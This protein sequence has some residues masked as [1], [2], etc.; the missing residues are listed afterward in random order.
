MTEDKKSN[1]LSM[2]L[3]SELRSLGAVATN[4]VS[5]LNEGSD[6][7]TIETIIL[8]DASL[9]AQII[10]VANSSK[11]EADIQRNSLYD[12]IVRIGHDGLRS[13]CITIGIIEHIPLRNH[14]QRIM[15][16][17]CLHRS[18]ETAIHAENLT[19]KMTNS[20]S[21]D[22]YIAGLLC[23]VGELAFLSSS[24][25]NLKEYNELTESGLT[26]EMAC[27]SLCDFDFDELSEQIVEKWEL[28]ILIN[29]AFINNPATVT[30]N[31]IKVAF[32]LTRAYYSGQN[33]KAFI[34]VSRSLV[35]DF[36]FSLKET[37]HFI[38]KGIESSQIEFNRYGS[39][40]QEK[41]NPFQ[42]GGIKRH[43][44]EYG[45][46]SNGK[47]FAR[48]LDI[49]GQNTAIKKFVVLAQKKAS[50]RVFY[51]I[52]VDSLHGYTSFDRVVIAEVK[53]KSELKAVNVSG[54][55]AQ[56]LF[57]GFSF[58][59]EVGGSTVSEIIDTKKPLYISQK[60]NPEIYECVDENIKRLSGVNGE[61][62]LSP[63]VKN[64][65]VISI[66]Y[67]DMGGKDATISEEQMKAATIMVGSVSKAISKNYMG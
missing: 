42:E 24:I 14:D 51:S 48:P 18:F 43:S 49:A 6:L 56:K 44:G 34:E 38:E 5:A 47:G 61:F 35:R 65:T 23:N 28:S 54:A 13:I 29:D 39:I 26:P 41:A 52:L 8:K 59:F 66:A 21:K 62:F 3:N 1:V 17:E 53:N 4:V 46:E 31:A 45:D 11:S 27:L 37:I 32:E 20:D 67:M 22:A 9:T 58:K 7:K 60:I 33:S 40:L 16:F 10:K 63:I 50:T 25:I 64:D 2:I 30:G 57:S 15:I 36:G 55:G 19:K 12:A